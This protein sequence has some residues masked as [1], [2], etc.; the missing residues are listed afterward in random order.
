MWWSNCEGMFS[1]TDAG[2]TLNFRHPEYK[3]RAC[4]N[5]LRDVIMSIYKVFSV[6]LTLYLFVNSILLAFIEFFY[7]CFLEFEDG[8]C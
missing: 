8:L 4:F 2:R 7:Y 1:N 5:T 3:A 6:N